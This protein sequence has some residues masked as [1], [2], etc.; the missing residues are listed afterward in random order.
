[1][2]CFIRDFVFHATWVENFLYK[3]LAS[4]RKKIVILTWHS[5]QIPNNIREKL[6]LTQVL[7][8]FRVCMIVKKILVCSIKYFKKYFFNKKNH[9][10]ICFFLHKIHISYTNIL[11]LGISVVKN[12]NKGT[13]YFFYNAFL[14]QS[15]L[16]CYV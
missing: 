11:L 4:S 12:L 10:I 13:Q 16:R 6:K 1:M 8:F 5:L 14:V 9:Q 2:F 3:H 7:L 15:P